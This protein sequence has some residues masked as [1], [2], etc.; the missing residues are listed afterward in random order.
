[1][2]WCGDHNC[3]RDARTCPHALED[4]DGYSEPEG[5][6]IRLYFPG[7]DCEFSKSPDDAAKRYELAEAKVDK[8]VAALQESVERFGD[9]VEKFIAGTYDYIMAD[10]S[11]DQA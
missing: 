8:A 1:M 9:A 2:E 4:F 7:P 5:A 10:G 11:H 6:P 3:G